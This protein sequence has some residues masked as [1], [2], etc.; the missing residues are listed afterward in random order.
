MQNP[1]GA[2]LERPMLPECE[3]PDALWTH[4]TQLSVHNVLSKVETEEAKFVAA[5]AETA[6]N[7]PL[8]PLIQKAKA[9]EV[10]PLPHLNR[11]LKNYQSNDLNE[12]N[13]YAKSGISKLLCYVM[14]LGKTFCYGTDLLNRSL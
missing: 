5:R 8:L 3:D 1:M 9:S 4:L 7:Y 11:L 13:H 6:L 2:G 14:G 10:K 12:F